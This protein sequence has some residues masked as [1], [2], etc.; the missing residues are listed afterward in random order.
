[1][2]GDAKIHSG[3][4]C[5]REDA[6]EEQHEI[7]EK[8]IKSSC[9][10]IFIDILPTLAVKAW[11]VSQVRAVPY[12]WYKAGHRGELSTPGIQYIRHTLQDATG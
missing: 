2:T 12:I 6:G 1:M 5:W 3:S 7:I 10:D 4:I 8:Y 9:S 11:L